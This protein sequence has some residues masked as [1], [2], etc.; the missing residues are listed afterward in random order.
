MDQD[1][2]LRRAGGDM[3]NIGRCSTREDHR[4]WSA[5]EV[6]SAILGISSI[7]GLCLFFKVPQI[8]GVRK[9]QGR[10]R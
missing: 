1:F 8:A 4:D 5:K 3:E 7:A 6:M 2:P 9:W 10:D